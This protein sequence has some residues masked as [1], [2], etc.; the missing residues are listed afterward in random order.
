MPDESGT[1]L[2]TPGGTRHPFPPLGDFI[3]RAKR[4]MST[5][6]S[7]EKTKA[8]SVFTDRG[9]LAF[10]AIIQLVLT[11]IIAPLAAWS[12]T[13][14]IDY[15]ERIT[16]IEASRFSSTDGDILRDRIRVVESA[17]SAN[18]PP[19]WLVT[20]MQKLENRLDRIEDRI[21]SR[22]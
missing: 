21:G 11:I 22:P 15:G 10:V 17:A 13:R 4:T 6:S 3:P 20:Q 16:R 5:E 12:L 2:E 14:I 1:I 7:T 19:A 18:V 9:V 8:G